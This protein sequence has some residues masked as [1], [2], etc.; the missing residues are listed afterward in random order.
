MSGM[1]IYENKVENKYPYTPLLVFLATWA[2]SIAL[3]QDSEK[4]NRSISDLGRL[5][6]DDGSFNIAA[7]VM[8]SGY[9]ILAI[10]FIL[11]YNHRFDLK[12]RF[13]LSFAASFSL[14]SIPQNIFSIGHNLGLFLLLFL[15]L[16]YILVYLTSMNGIITILTILVV[17]ILLTLFVNMFHIY[18]LQFIYIVIFLIIYPHY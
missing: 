17:G 12:D 10:Y 16:F 2:L 7:P 8:F 11:Q 5:L 13:N 4:I 3:Y 14:I 15:A 6:L 1:I 18:Y 9:I